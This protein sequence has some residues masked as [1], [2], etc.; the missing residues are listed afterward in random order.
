MSL[1]CIQRFVLLGLGLLVSWIIDIGAAGIEES[2]K[3]LH[4]HKHNLG[5]VKC[6]L[7]QSVTLPCLFL[8]RSSPSEQDL[9]GTNDSPRIKWSHVQSGSEQKEVAVLVA[10]GNVV[11][12]ARGYE[13]RVSLPGYPHNRYNAT[14]VLTSARSSDSG[15]YRC[16]VVLGINDEQ[17]T[18]HLEVTGLVFHYR[19]A[20]NR[21]ALTYPEAV[22]SCQEN[23]GAIASPDQLQAAFEDGLD[24]CDAGWLSDLSVRYPIKSPRPGCYGD[25]NNLPGVRTYGERDPQENY[26]VYCYTEDSQGDV[27]YVPERSTLDEARTNCVKDGGSLATVGQL[28]SAWRKGLDQCDPGWLADTSVRYPIRNPRRNCGGQEPGVRTLYQYPNRTGFPNP[29]RKFGSYC[30]KALQVATPTPPGNEQQGPGFMLQ[31]D[32][33]LIKPQ[34]QSQETRQEIQLEFNNVLPANDT[35][36]STAGHGLFQMK[37]SDPVTPRGSHGI[38]NEINALSSE[39]QLPASSEDDKQETVTSEPLGGS[40]I[41]DMTSETSATTTKLLKE[42]FTHK[43]NE[44]DSITTTVRDKARQSSVHK[45]EEEDWL[46][47]MVDRESKSGHVAWRDFAEQSVA[48]SSEESRSIEKSVEEHTLI[49]HANAISE[50][51][52]NSPQFSWISR[53]SEF[54]TSS[55]AYPETSELTTPSSILLEDHEKKK[56]GAHSASNQ[57]TS[58]EVPKFPIKTNSKS[59]IT[60]PHT[61]PNQE[62]EKELFVNHHEASNLVDSSAELTTESHQ[63]PFQ[64]IQPESFP[65]IY[66]KVKEDKRGLIDIAHQAKTD[67]LT[68]TAVHLDAVDIDDSKHQG[69]TAVLDTFSIIPSAANN[70]LG[71]GRPKAYHPGEWDRKADYSSEEKYKL[72]TEEPSMTTQQVLEENGSNGL[73]TQTTKISDT[74]HDWSDPENIITENKHSKI[75]L[76]KPVDGE[77]V[78]GISGEVNVRNEGIDTLITTSELPNTANPTLGRQF[79]DDFFFATTDI[80]KMAFSSIASAHETKSHGEEEHLYANFQ[81]RQ[82]KEISFSEKLASGLKKDIESVTTGEVNAFATITPILDDNMLLHKTN[83]ETGTMEAHQLPDTAN[84]PNGNVVESEE[85]GSFP[86]PPYPLQTGIALST[87]VPHMHPYQSLVEKEKHSFSTQSPMDNSELFSTKQKQLYK[88]HGWRVDSTVSTAT[89]ETPSMFSNNAKKKDKVFILA[90]ERNMTFTDPTNSW[91]TATRQITNYVSSTEVPVS[92]SSPITERTSLPLNHGKVGDLHGTSPPT[93]TV[94]I[95]TLTGQSYLNGL[96]EHSEVESGTLRSELMQKSSDHKV[97]LG[98]TEEQELNVPSSS[99]FSPYKPKAQFGKSKN[100]MLTSTGDTRSEMGETWSESNGTEEDLGSGGEEDSAQWLLDDHASA[101]GETHPCSHNPCLHMGTCQSNGSTYS[102]ICHKGYSGENC[103]IDIDECLSNPCQNGGTCIDEIN[104]FLCLCLPSYGGSTCGKDTEGCDHNWHKFQGSCYRYFPQRRPWEEAER[105]CRRRAGHLTSIHSEDEQKFINSFGRE[106]TWIGLNDR[107]VEQDFQWTDNTA[108][109]YDSW[110][111][112]Q[113][114]NFFAGGEDCVVMVSHEEGKWNDVPCNYNLPYIC[115]KGTV[116]CSA[117]PVVRDAYLIGKRREKYSIHSTVRYQCQD[118]FIQRHI[119]SIRCHRNGR[120]DRPRILCVKPRRNH[121]T[122]RHH[123]QHRHHPHKQHHHHHNHH[124]HHHGHHHQHK[125]HWERRKENRH[126]NHRV[127]DTY[128]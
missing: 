63:I 110:Q 120:W 19:A 86:S 106:N 51:T 44:M 10:R 76:G 73:V 109:Q 15:V 101:E 56:E 6:G 116:L 62:W 31:E 30:Y 42:T 121:R 118:G 38:K 93:Y 100:L 25:R 67:N 102:C 36:T 29:S 119:P 105:D 95:D 99:I 61:D 55:S 46:L 27:Y 70:P 66:N 122:R 96:P 69:Q 12:V 60:D 52:I 92:T 103:E 82:G 45:G 26:D 1:L 54:L 117:P 49:K 13:G 85:N 28:Y 11:K 40:Y 24:N 8:V 128:Y 3:P 126:P 35:L 33:G 81:E 47:N 53:E 9:N 108:L 113:P 17:D 23:S 78:D 94:S 97:L 84:I 48:D 77:D 20:S 65:S 22:R 88:P 39:L 114:D 32:L 90:N 14:L 75:V 91:T 37:S 115:K 43:T 50:D 98:S 112:N 125:S 5:T 107:T 16:E 2:V 34:L 123:H 83:V 104:S 18:V 89:D 21:Y 68:S 80:S 57:T 79:I 127:K 74:K 41:L 59:F 111:K 4:I 7:A 124:H 71:N 64:L 58:A 87:D 72:V